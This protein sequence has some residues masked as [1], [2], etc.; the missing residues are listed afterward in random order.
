MKCPMCQADSVVS[1]SR[2]LVH[3]RRVRRRWQCVDCGQRW[4]TYETIES[5]DVGPKREATEQR[6]RWHE[7]NDV[8]AK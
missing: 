7:R 2:C 5:I 3:T 6:K 8:G 4:T 1:D